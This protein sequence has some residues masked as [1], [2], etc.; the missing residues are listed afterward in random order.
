[1][2]K[3][4]EHRKMSPAELKAE[5][6]KKKRPGKKFKDVGVPESGE[7]ILRVYDENMNPEKDRSDEFYIIGKNG[8]IEI[9][10]QGKYIDMILKKALASNNPGSTLDR[11]NYARYLITEKEWDEQLLK[12]L[13]SQ[14]QSAKMYN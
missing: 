6:I 4:N 7:Y 12:L 2:E 13:D 11:F 10:E 9:Y 8:D 1:M 5:E 3:T 14:K